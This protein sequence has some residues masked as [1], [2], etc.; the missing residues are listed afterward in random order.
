MLKDQVDL[1]LGLLALISA[2]YGCW[3]WATPRIKDRRAV[4][5]AVN[6]VLV[7]RPATPF[8]PITGQPAEPAVPGLGERLI[9]M[10]DSID[11]LQQQSSEQMAKLHEVEH[12]VKNNDGSSMKDS[13]HRLEAQMGT[14]EAKISEISEQVG[15]IRGYVEETLRSISEASRE[16][17]KALSQAS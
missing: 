13:T 17:L 1:I 9:R 15:A 2:S 5:V 11:A 10:Q 6:T 7:G 12:E 16:A 4:R 3:R 14:Q 8:N